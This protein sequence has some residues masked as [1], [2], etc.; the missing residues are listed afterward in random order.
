MK[1][2]A[3]PHAALALNENFKQ[4]GKETQAAKAPPSTQRDTY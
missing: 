2:R 4:K 3:A 1:V